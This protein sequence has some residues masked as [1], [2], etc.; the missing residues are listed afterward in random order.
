M[1]NVHATQVTSSPMFMK[2]RPSVLFMVPKGLSKSKTS[3]PVYHSWVESLPKTAQTDIASTPEWKQATYGSSSLP[4][5]QLKKFDGDPL[6]WPDCSSM[7]MMLICLWME[8]CNTFRTL[9]LVEQS[10][11]LKD[12]VTVGILT[13]KHWKNWTL[14]LEN[15]HLECKSYIWQIEKDIANEEWQTAWSEKLIRYCVNYSLDL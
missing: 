13:I 15:P 7:F 8:R 3:T 9:C 1:H 10:L 2:P 5:L 12:M 14:D 4:K 6:Q 11:Q